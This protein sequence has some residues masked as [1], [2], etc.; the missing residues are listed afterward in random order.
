MKRWLPL[1]LLV[2]LVLGL[3]LSVALLVFSEISH[4]RLEAANDAV[5]ESLAIQAAIQEILALTADA[6]TGQRGYMLMEREEYLAPYTAAAAKIEQRLKQLRD[7]VRQR[8]VEQRDRA[9]RLT[10]LVGKRMNELESTLTLQ[11]RA[12]REAA[13]GL[14][15]TDIGL[16]TMDDIRALAEEMITEERSGLA[17][18]NSTWIHDIDTSR[19]GMQMVTALTIALLLVV[20]LLAGREITMRENV[21][22]RMAEDQRRLEALVEE[23]TAELSELSAHLQSVSEQERAKLARD[24]HDEMGSILVSAKMDISWVQARVQAAD[25]ESGAKLA[26]AQAALDEGV[27]IKRRLIEE[28]RPTLLDNLGLGAAVEWQ[29]TE[30]CSRAG[31]GCN[32]NLPDDQVEVPADISIALFRIVQE[33]LTN[34]VRYAQATSVDIDILPV[35]DG[36]TL[37]VR[38][39][40]VGIPDGAPHNRMS[41]GIAGMR[42]RVRALNGEFK[43]V[44]EP[45]KG[46]RIEVY[47]PFAQTSRTGAI[48]TE[49]VVAIG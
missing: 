38:D 31:L 34:V 22:K 10:T 20:W 42:Q 13:L 24:I 44:G 30:V 39:D 46:T 33:A 7:H 16:R 35:T 37:S 12:G 36:I 26:R 45:G 32:L 27:E 4:R 3:V 1:K 43:I 11:R 28:L 19:V 18:Y 8:S 9:G 40:G 29:A 21:R 41:H 48:D 23:R 47:V 5:S 2:P 49:G 17:V 25:P 15:G 14:L 6:E